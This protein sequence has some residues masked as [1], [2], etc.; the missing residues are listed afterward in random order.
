MARLQRLYVPG[1][2]QHVLQRCRPDELIAHDAGDF[3]ALLDCL[4]AAMREQGVALHA[5]ALLP[6]H[7]H[8]LGTPR[9]AQSMSL[10]MQALGRRYVR[11]FNRRHGRSG[12][13]W[14]TRYRSTVLED[15]PY[16][17]S[18]YRYI[19]QNAC[20]RGLVDDPLHYSWSS[21]AHHVGSVNSPAITDHPVY[22]QLGNTPF[23]R[24]RRYRELC[25]RSPGP[26][27]LEAIRSA[28]WFGWALGSPEFLARLDQNANRRTQKLARGRPRGEGAPI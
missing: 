3:D 6:E 23:E 14:Q 28:T 26:T 18:C 11:Y 5:Y 16:V 1:H 12:T 27:E 25:A 13:L 19:E 20:R 24:Q 21:Y 22:W 17:L 4:N 10:A 7:F 15:Q 2:A 8:L 9:S